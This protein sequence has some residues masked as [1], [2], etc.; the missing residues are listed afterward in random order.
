[1]LIKLL[2]EGTGAAKVP[3]DAFVVFNFNAFRDNEDE[4]FDSTFMRNRPFKVRLGQGDLLMGLE[5]ALK[6][7]KKSEKSQ[8]LIHYDLAYGEFGCPPRIQKCKIYY[9]L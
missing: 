8:F 7:M 3:D 4:P 2:R 5:E 6:T 1:M 9:I